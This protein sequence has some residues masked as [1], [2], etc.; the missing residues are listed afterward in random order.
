[1]AVPVLLI[2]GIVILLPRG[3]DGPLEFSRATEPLGR[4]GGAL[5]HKQ[6]AAAAAE[7][8]FAIV[9]DAGST[10]SRVHIFKFLVV[11]GAIELQFDKFEQLRPGLSSYAED[12]PAAAASLKPLLDLALETVPQSL[13]ASTHVM[14]GATAG[15]RLLPDGK[16][17]IILAEVRKW[18]RA[19]YPFAFEDGDVKILSGVDEGAFAWL[20]LNYLLGNLGKKEHETVASIDLGE[21]LCVKD[22]RR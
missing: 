20:T 14:V 17:D 2:L 1:M 11:D 7:E 19:G 8:K 10:G 16:A 15:L 6:A 4:V 12:P 22:L 21:Y 5:K 3:G 9:V 18:L 13:Q